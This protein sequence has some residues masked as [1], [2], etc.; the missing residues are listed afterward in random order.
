M[1]DSLFPKTLVSY[2]IAADRA[3]R[4]LRGSEH[5]QCP[6]ISPE[7]LADAFFEK[8]PPGQCA[9]DWAHEHQFASADDRSDDFMDSNEADDDNHTPPLF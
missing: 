3:L 8:I 5:S 2:E 7:R 6:D 9:T 1:S 4:I